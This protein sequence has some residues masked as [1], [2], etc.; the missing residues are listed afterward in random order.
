MVFVVVAFFKFVNGPTYF[1]CFLRAKG[2]VFS[3]F[4]FEATS[5]F[6]TSMFVGQFKNL[7]FKKPVELYFII[8]QADLFICSDSYSADQ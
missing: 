1:I 3:V 6:S 8:P 2:E 7:N 5:I 4:L